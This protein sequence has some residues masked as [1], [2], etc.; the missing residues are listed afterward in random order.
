MLH[1][2]WKEFKYDKMDFF[3][4]QLNKQYACFTAIGNGLA[5]I[6]ISL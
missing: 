4:Y 5:F 3:E 1:L 2:T 6:Y